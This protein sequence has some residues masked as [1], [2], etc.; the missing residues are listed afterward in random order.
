[1]LEK[2]LAEVARGHGDGPNARPPCGSIAYGTRKSYPGGRCALSV[3]AGQFG[4]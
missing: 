1:M 2:W 4:E 3:K